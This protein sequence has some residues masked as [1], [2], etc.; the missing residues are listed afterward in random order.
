[1]YGASGAGKSFLALDLSAAV[2]EGATWFDCRV[3][4]AQV[5]YVALEGEHGFR[6]RVNAWK[7]HRGRDMPHALRFV[8][9]PF[10][11][12]NTDDLNDLAAAVI[13]SGAAGGLLILDTLN[14][15]SVGAD[16]NSSKDMGEIIQAAKMLQTKLG[17]T[18]LFVHHTGKDQTKGLRGHS[19]LHAA[20]DAAIEVNRS[21]NLREWVIKKSKDDEDCANFP[22]RLERIEIGTDDLGEPLTSC[23]VVPESPNAEFKRV[24][25][26]KSGNQ[27]VVWDKLG[28]MLHAAGIDRP[29]GAPKSLPLK[30]PAI[31]LELV[32]EALRECLAC[33]PKRKT[34]RVHQALT[35]L[36]SRGLI[37]IEGG[38]VWKA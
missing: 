30:R 15:A 23:A 25:P 2:A 38:F 35:G 28:D 14:R 27:R 16:E 34:E 11:L 12:R 26:P 10:D 37:V 20:L 5:V 3:N 7:K 24:L 36:Q 19:S 31:P 33:D 8:M 22:F 21:G 18:V 32:I 6:Q 29:E 4:T 1:M 13:A 9:Q 17:G